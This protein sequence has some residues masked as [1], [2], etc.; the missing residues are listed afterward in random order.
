M[1]QYFIEGNKVKV[2]PDGAINLKKSLPPATYFVKFNQKEGFFLERGDNFGE[3]GTL[4]GDLS[5]RTNRI[6]DTYLDRK[7]KNVNTGILLSGLKG[8]GKTLQSKIVSNT[9]RIEY[10]IPTIIVAETYNPAELALY[11]KD[12]SDPALILFEEFEKLYRSSGIRYNHVRNRD[13]VIYTDESVDSARKANVTDMQEGL[14]TLLDG[15]MNSNK[16]FIF[17]CNSTRDVNYLLLNRPGRVWYHFKYSGIEESVIDS[18]CKE[19][20][21]GNEK[22]I[23]EIKQ[24]S[25]YLDECFTFDVMQ[26]IVEETLRQG[27]L[28]LEA[29][30]YLNVEPEPFSHYY[31]INVVSTDPKYNIYKPIY[32]E[33][34]E[35]DNYL[36]SSPFEV[37]V[38]FLVSN[39]KELESVKEIVHSENGIYSRG[40]SMDKFISGGGRH[41]VDMDV[42]ESFEVGFGGKGEPQRV[43][44]EIILDKNYLVSSTRKSLVYKKYGLEFHFT[45]EKRFTSWKMLMD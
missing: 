17:T 4:Y 33:H 32:P 21:E 37:R 20:L 15:V 9:L 40:K 29:M 19:K 26:A 41:R 36:S 44:V 39:K 34:R 22:A 8:S 11:L 27:V 10:K 7:A 2:V 28:P 31:E 3:V 23:A 1:S 13:D 35:I 5:D 38:T 30:E 12:I 18:Y 6:V 42:E 24:I 43:N 45:K 16:L 25:D 14:L